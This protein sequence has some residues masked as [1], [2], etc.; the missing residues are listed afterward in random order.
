[1]PWR[2]EEVL[3]YFCINIGLLRP[4]A[5]ALQYRIYPSDREKREA[6]HLFQR[7]QNASEHVVHYNDPHAKQF[8]IVG[9]LGE[10][11]IST[12]LNFHYPFNWR[13]FIS[14]GVQ[15]QFVIEGWRVQ[16]TTGEVVDQPAV[17]VFHDRDIRIKDL[18][19]KLQPWLTRPL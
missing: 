10:L 14:D 1:M 18:A 9:T 12:Q 8:R 3:T 16:E 11:W 6:L 5:L 7:I 2:H 13:T 17:F 19:E 4:E 15:T